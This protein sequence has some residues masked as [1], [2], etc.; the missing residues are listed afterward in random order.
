MSDN[1][2]SVKIVRSHDIRLD[3]E[4]TSWI[5]EIKNRYKAAS[6]K[7]A[8][9]VNSEQLLFNWQFGKELVLRKAEEKWGSGI[10]EQIS[11]DLQESF[12][13]TKGFSARNIWYMKQWYL[14]YSSS[15]S[16]KKL[17]Q[18]AAEID[19]IPEFKLNQLE[20]QTSSQKLQQ[21]VAE[22]EMPRTLAYVPWGHHIIII[23][24]YR[25]V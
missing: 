17:Q 20:P 18:L 22:M 21:A 13:G 6:I 14:F 10:V 23:D 25:K 19:S 5:Q 3:A 8:V 24:G 2:K 1:N 15:G 16:S 12:P 9:K 4:Y 11:L 7:A